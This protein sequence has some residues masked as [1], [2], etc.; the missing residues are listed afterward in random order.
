MKFDAFMRELLKGKLPEYPFPDNVQKS[1]INLPEN[2]L[3]Y[4]YYFEVNN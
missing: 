3:V 2:G 1:D 4:D